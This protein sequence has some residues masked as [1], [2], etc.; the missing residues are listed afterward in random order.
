M[1]RVQRSEL[2]LLPERDGRPE[3]YRVLPNQLLFKSHSHYDGVKALA[4]SP[5]E[6][7]AEGTP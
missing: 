5:L 3:G 6:P 1:S 4:C 2:A 7:E